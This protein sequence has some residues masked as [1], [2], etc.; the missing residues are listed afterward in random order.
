M[1]EPAV[2]SDERVAGVQHS[3][4]RVYIM[5]KEMYPAVTMNIITHCCED[6]R[7]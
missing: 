6:R 1:S 2:G 7:V 5:R 3:D 4:L